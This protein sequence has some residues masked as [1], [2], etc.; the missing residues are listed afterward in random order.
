MRKFII[1]LVTFASWMEMTTA[2]YAQSGLSMPMT[3]KDTGDQQYAETDVLAQAGNF[4]DGWYRNW[5]SHNLLAEATGIAHA[6]NSG[7]SATSIVL[8]AAQAMCA[9]GASTLL[10]NDTCALGGFDV[11]N[12]TPTVGALTGWVG[13]A[14]SLGTYEVGTP[15]GAP[16][17]LSGIAEVSID[18]VIKEHYPPAGSDFI[19]LR[20][21]VGSSLVLVQAIPGGWRVTG[22]L[23]NANGSGTVLNEE[24]G[25]DWGGGHFTATERLFVGDQFNVNSWVS[26]NVGSAGNES[27][28]PEYSTSFG[29]ALYSE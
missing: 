11:C 16:N 25:T 17:V 20:V 10:A 4:I 28:T 8:S 26:A 13:Q 27:K 1:C 3:R 12:S 9:Q 18:I 7:A 14:Q 6:T 19:F 5:Q 15:E 23:A 21:E 2:L 29:V 24:Y 22:G